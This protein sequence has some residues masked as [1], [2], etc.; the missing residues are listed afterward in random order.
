MDLTRLDAPRRVP[1]AL[2]VVLR[3]LPALLFLCAGV[4]YNLI[5]H[6]DPDV[7]LSTGPGAIVLDLEIYLHIWDQTP[8][9]VWLSAPLQ[10]AGAQL[11]ALL[12]VAA[13]ALAC[14]FERTCP[15]ARLI[16]AGATASVVLG[17]KS[18]YGSWTPGSCD[19]VRFVP[20]VV[21]GAI[22]TILL[23]RER[24]DRF[25]NRVSRVFAC[26]MIAAPFLPDCSEFWQVYTPR[27][28][29]AL[30][31]AFAVPLLVQGF[32]RNTPDPSAVTPV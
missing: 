21:A 3:L 14:V 15:W 19:L 9:P 29:Q 28:A 31:L 20:L 30:M 4:Q 8:G 26:A 13:A 18:Y 22:A 17:V 11:A 12:I 5:Q 23:D 7:H 10:L 25:A 32:T 16:G 1:R 24:R 6:S 2:D 27:G